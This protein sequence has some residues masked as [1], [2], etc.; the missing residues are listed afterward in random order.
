MLTHT[1]RGG[2]TLEYMTNEPVSVLT[3]FVKWIL[4]ESATR[5]GERG[6][7]GVNLVVTDQ[8]RRTTEADTTL[9]T[10]EAGIMQIMRAEATHRR[11]MTAVV[12]MTLLLVWSVIS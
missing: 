12:T 8:D 3:D 10:I 4:S 9:M 5:S 1:T 2:Q 6:V 7:I 11:L